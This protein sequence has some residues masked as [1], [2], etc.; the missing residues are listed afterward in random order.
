[1]AG[2]PN[3]PPNNGLGSDSGGLSNELDRRAAQAAK[4]ARIRHVRQI[5]E[6]LPPSLYLDLMPDDEAGHRRRLQ[7]FTDAQEQRTPTLDGLIE[8][9]RLATPEAD[10][11]ALASDD[12][13]RISRWIAQQARI[14]MMNRPDLS[15]EDAFAS[16][17]ALFEKSS[18]GQMLARER[19]IKAQPWFPRTRQEYLNIRL[20]QKPENV[21]RLKD[22]YSIGFDGS[23]L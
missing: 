13:L 7:Q 15:R 1:M 17:R 11:L 16:A 4:D 2:Y 22:M 18:E 19:M 23:E 8:R 14:M 5:R 6:L 12:E 3:D 10:P 21:Q 20:S 9:E